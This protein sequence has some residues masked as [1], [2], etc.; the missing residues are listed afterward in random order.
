MLSMLMEEF[1]L[2]KK[3]NQGH[4]KLTF[5][6]LKRRKGSGPKIDPKMSDWEILMNFVMDLEIVKPK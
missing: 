2:L 6:L 3:D 4:N 1:N 5:R